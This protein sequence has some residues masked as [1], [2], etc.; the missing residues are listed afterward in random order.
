MKLEEVHYITLFS[1]DY[2]TTRELSVEK[3][4]LAIPRETIREHMSD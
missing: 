3:L 4:G 2:Q 1:A